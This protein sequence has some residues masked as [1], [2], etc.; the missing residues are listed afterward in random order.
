ML[1]GPLEPGV[2]QRHMMK[3]LKSENTKYIKKVYNPAYVPK[4]HEIETFWPIYNKKYSE[5]KSSPETVQGFRKNFTKV[6]NDV[7]ADSGISFI[8]RAKRNLIAIWYKGIR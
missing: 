4:V 3:R 1:N 6:M 2:C 7:P 5:W 8:Q